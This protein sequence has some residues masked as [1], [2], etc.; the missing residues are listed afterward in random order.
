MKRPPDK[1]GILILAAGNA[2]RFG[3]PKQLLFYQHKTFIRRIAEEA[4]RAL[5]NALVVV[6]GA[7][8]ELI[9]PEI[10]DLTFVRNEE[11]EEGM[12]TSISKGITEMM[13]LFPALEDVTILVCD[14]PHVSASLLLQMAAQKEATGK[15]MIAC[16]YNNTI[17]TPSLFDKHYFNALCTLNGQ[18][19]AKVLLQKFPEDVAVVDFP[20]GA[21]DIDTREDYE[22]LIQSV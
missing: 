20:S 6:T 4:T 14:Q 17:G 3:S 7:N 16:A 1:H 8:A 21:I 9:E 13:K 5:G 22:R 2:S 12:G 18:Q 19:G 11:W 15:G 10:A